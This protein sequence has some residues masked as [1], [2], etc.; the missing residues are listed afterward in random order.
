L[1][2]AFIPV[3]VKEDRRMDCI[4]CKILNKEIPSS[5]VFENDKILAFNDISPQAPVHVVIIPKI[6]V[7][8]ANEVKPTGSIMNS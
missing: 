4:F 8:S 2:C 7:A 6:H 1:F 3:K 5:V